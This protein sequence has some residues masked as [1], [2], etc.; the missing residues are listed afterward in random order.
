MSRAVITITEI[1]SF[2]NVSTWDKPAVV[3]AASDFRWSIW[4]DP[5]KTPAHNPDGFLVLGEVIGTGVAPS[6]DTAEW[7]ARYA[8]EMWKAQRDNPEKETT[9]E[10]E[11]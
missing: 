9:I 5:M 4:R 3:P 8:I 11:L 1:P 10:V 7:E 6:R 2:V